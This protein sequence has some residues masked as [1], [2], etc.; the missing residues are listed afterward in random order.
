MSSHCPPI[1]SRA[2]QLYLMVGI[3]GCDPLTGL[4]GWGGWAGGLVGTGQEAVELGK[5]R[6]E[7]KGSGGGVGGGE[8][9]TGREQENGGEG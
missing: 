6:R 4:T 8:D 9:G 2:A 3:S 5:R 1:L 7:A